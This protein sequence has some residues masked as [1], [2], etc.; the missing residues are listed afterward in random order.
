MVDTSHFA[1]PRPNRDQSHRCVALLCTYNGARFLELQLESLEAQSIGAVDVYVSDDGSTDGTL[2]ILCEWQ[3]RWRRGAFRIASG[4]RRGFAENFRHLAISTEPNAD[5]IAFCDQDDVWHADKLAVAIDALRRAP[6]SIPGLY[7][8][9]TRLVDD[10]GGPIGLSPL[11]AKPPSFRNAVVQ[12]IAGGNTMVFNRS[13]F[14]L[15]RESVRRTS[16][17]IHDWWAY[18]VVS[19]VGGN[20]HYDP[21]PHIN[22]RQHGANLIGRDSGWRARTRRIQRLR[23]G[24]FANWTTANLAALDA[25]QDL[26]TS[27]ALETIADLRRI[28][29]TAGLDAVV[30]LSRAKLYRQTP[31]GDLSLRLA[32]FL[33]RL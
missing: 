17:V 29:S 31:M 24:D 14:D 16:F 9:R 30:R 27:G 7:G 5:Y 18:I 3:R 22:Y 10:A 23:R 8:S 21:I 26:L 28:R 2:N 13:G 25:C 15:F 4:P 19:G 6:S 20:V 12:S 1:S 11:F 32:A 33:G